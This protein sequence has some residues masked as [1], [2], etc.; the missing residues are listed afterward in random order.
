MNKKVVTLLVVALAALVGLVYTIEQS[1]RPA[2]DRAGIVAEGEA[3]HEGH[4]HE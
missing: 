1:A 2:S 3:G 4:S